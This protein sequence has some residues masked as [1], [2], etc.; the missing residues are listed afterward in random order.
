MKKTMKRIFA[1]GLC[2]LMLV[3]TLV[4]PTNAASQTGFGAIGTR[5]VDA[6]L[7]L[8]KMILSS[9]TKYDG[10]ADDLDVQVELWRKNAS[11]G[12]VTQCL[13]RIASDEDTTSVSVSGTSDYGYYFYCAKSTHNVSA[14]GQTWSCDLGPVYAT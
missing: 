4:F 9:F 10:I 12:S 8:D 1:L 6:S 11:T 7:Y 13:D 3:T 14:A 2:N 5:Q